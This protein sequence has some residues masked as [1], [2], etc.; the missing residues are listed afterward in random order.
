MRDVDYCSDP[1]DV[2]LFAGA[3]EALRRLKGPDSGSSLS[4][5]RADWLR[6]LTEENYRAVQHELERSSVP[7]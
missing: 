2:Q 1:A 3:A 6:Y 4:Q 5:T 7:A